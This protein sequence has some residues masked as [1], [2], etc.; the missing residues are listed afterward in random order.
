MHRLFALL[1]AVVSLCLCGFA[2]EANTPDAVSSRFA[3]P[4]A[5]APLLTIRKNVEEV[6]VTFHA[7]DRSKRPVLNLA[8]E[9]LAIVDD[10]VPVRAIS[11]FQVAEDLPLSV[12]L[13]VD[14]SDSVA[15][16]FAAE[17]DASAAFI[18]T[19]VR[20]NDDRVLLVSFRDKV[21]TV[22]RMTGDAE[23]L[24]SSLREIKVG[25][26]TALYDAIVATSDRL[27]RT[28]VS[29][30]RRAMVVITDGDDTDSYHVLDDAVRAALR[31]DVAVYAITLRSKSLTQQGQAV[32]KR[33]AEASGGLA[34]VLQRPDD[35]AHAMQEIEHD[36]RTQF[37]VTYHPQTDVTGYHSLKVSSTDT[38]I[39]IRARRGYFA[40]NRN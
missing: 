19:L 18:R 25:G 38:E 21:E 31:N 37:L 39:S 32:L 17:K 22:R 9:S 30:G 29:A 23:E 14:A 13:M 11:A 28:D 34:Y 2:S 15:R 7:L 16:D 35:L 6:R 5:A 40:A 24:A 10:G 33:L 1:L 12:A 26:L 36:L 3:A 4:S 27:A 20:T 8:P